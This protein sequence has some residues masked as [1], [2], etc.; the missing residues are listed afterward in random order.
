MPDRID[1]AIATAET[2]AR[3]RAAIALLNRQD[4]AVVVDLPADITDLEVLS[5]INGILQ[6]TD[7]LRA[8]RPANRIVAATSMPRALVG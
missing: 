1:A 4:R 3:A 7:Q 8:Q 6:M 5:L 2:P